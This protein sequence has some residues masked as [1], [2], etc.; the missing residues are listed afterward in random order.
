MNYQN[1][2]ITPDAHEEL[3]LRE[4]TNR[5]LADTQPDVDEEWQRFCNAKRD[6]MGITRHQR[7]KN[8]VFIAAAC[9]AVAIILT[10]LAGFYLGT[11]RGNSSLLATVTGTAADSLTVTAP[12]GQRCQLTLPDGTKI[13]L[14]A[15]TTVRYPAAFTKQNRN[16][17]LNGEAFF[18]V[19][20][21]P[22]H[23]FVVNTPYLVTK[24]FGTQFNIRCYSADD[25]HVTLV[26]GRIEVTPILNKELQTDKTVAV[27]P[28]NDVCVTESGTTEVTRIAAADHL[29]WEDGT[30]EFDDV[31]L[32]DVLGEL[33]VWYHAPV[34]CHDQDILRHKIHLSLDRNISL[35]QAVDLVNSLGVAHVAV[36]NGNISV[37]K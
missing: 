17:E 24:V 36:V 27:T 19:T 3:L 21:D 26:T 2:T 11:S 22:E 34:I 9:A 16:V 37:S 29:S 4:A 12:D 30:F 31:A 13:W 15:G 8:S 25:C 6:S 10:G 32:G 20:K 1:D 33:S 28:G 5:A 23:P 18:D 35:S 14:S 7:R